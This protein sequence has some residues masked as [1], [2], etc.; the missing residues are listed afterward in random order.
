MPSSSDGKRSRTSSGTGSRRKKT[1]VAGAVYI[2][3]AL[4]DVAREQLEF[5]L[6]HKCGGGCEHCIRLSEIIVPLT[7]IFYKSDPPARKIIIP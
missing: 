1:Q 5:L 3:A 2:T 7:K 6:T 4:A